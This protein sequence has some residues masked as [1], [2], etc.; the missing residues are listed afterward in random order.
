MGM[1]VI[2]MNSV[3]MAGNVVRLQWVIGDGSKCRGT[4]LGLEK[5]LKDYHVLSWEFDFYGSL[6]VTKCDSTG[7]FFQ[8][9]KF[10]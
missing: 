7:S 4:H 10:Y 6:Q 3:E 2:H 5:A 8:R 1:T 9:Q